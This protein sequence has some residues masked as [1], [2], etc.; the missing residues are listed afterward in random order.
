LTEGQ[1]Q[2]GI[3]IGWVMTGFSPL[4]KKTG[5]QFKVEEWKAFTL[6]KKLRLLKEITKSME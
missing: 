1:Y 2:N 5:D 6:K 4:W 3:S